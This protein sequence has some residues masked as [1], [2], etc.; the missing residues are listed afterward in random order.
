[1]RK[2]T[3]CWLFATKSGRLSTDRILRVR[4]VPSQKL[5]LQNVKEKQNRKKNWDV[6]S[7][8]K[9]GTNGSEN[10]SEYEEMREKDQKNEIGENIIEQIPI[11]IEKYYAVYYDNRFYIGRALNVYENFSCKVKFLKSKLDT[12]IWP[13]EE[14]VEVVENRFIFYGPIDLIGNG[15]FQLKGH[16]KI[17]IEKKYKEVKKNLLLN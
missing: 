17:A 4:G 15:P 9:S 16:Q 1:M 6:T 11:H 7:S 14:D 8:P 12:F 5:S 3:L 13:R 2:S 10:E